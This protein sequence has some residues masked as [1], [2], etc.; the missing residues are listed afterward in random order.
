MDGWLHNEWQLKYNCRLRRLVLGYMTGPAHETDPADLKTENGRSEP[1]WY[2]TQWLITL[3]ARLDSKE[4]P[5]LTGVKMAATVTI[6]WLVW[7]PGA[8]P[9]WCWA[10]LRCLFKSPLPKGSRMLKKD[11]EVHNGG[12]AAVFRQ[13]FA[14]CNCA[15]LPEISPVCRE[16]SFQRLITCVDL[17][18]WQ[19]PKQQTVTERSDTVC[20]CLEFCFMMQKTQSHEM[21]IQICL[22]QYYI[23][24]KLLRCDK[25]EERMLKGINTT[26]EKTSLRLSHSTVV[27]SQ[28]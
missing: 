25:I 15:H 9:L 5:D 14:F 21:M 6:R 11:Q 24:L 19:W 16:G 1:Q 23:F 28:K 22:K 27:H 7:L 18:L 12:W 17:R 20:C 10:G 26:T 8:R 13:K 2:Q 4:R 3:Q